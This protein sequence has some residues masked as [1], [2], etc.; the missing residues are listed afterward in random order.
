MFALTTL[1]ALTLTSSIAVPSAPAAATPQ[2]ASGQE[3]TVT[4]V[5]IKREADTFTLMDQRGQEVKV[6]LTSETTVKEKKR[7][8][9]SAAARTMPR[10]ICSAALTWK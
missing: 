7:R 4:G 10:P 1:V 9:R 6:T 3:T 2:V 8:I 5:I